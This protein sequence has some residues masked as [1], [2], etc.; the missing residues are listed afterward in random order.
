MD[1]VPG[2]TQVGAVDLLLKDRQQLLSLL[3]HNLIAAQERLKWYADKKRVDW[4]FNVGD[5]VYLILQPYKQA[6]VHHQKPGKFAPR[7]YD[8]F[9]ILQKIGQVSYQLDLP[10]GFLPVIHPVF[11]QSQSQSEPTCAA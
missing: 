1:Y 9:Q 11:V 3:K 5:W 10:A 4:S 6:S 2:T 8:S 7:F